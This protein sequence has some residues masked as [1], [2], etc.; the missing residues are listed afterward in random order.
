M[1]HAA[2]DAEGSWV[3][4]KAFRGVFHAS[5]AL[6]TLAG[7]TLASPA[8][9]DVKAG[10]DAWA[11]G[12]FPKAVA[13]WKGPAD[14][15]DPDAQFNLAQAYKLGRG[16][17]R[18]FTRAESLYASA[19]TKGHLQA[20]DNYGL[21]LFQRGERAKAMPYIRAAAE[22]GDARA[23]YIYGLAMFNADGVE[24][25]W[26]R[27]Y[28]YVSMAQQS[29]LPQ[30]T[31]A[32]AQMDQHIAMADRQKAVVLAGKLAAETEARRARQ[33]A[34]M[35]LGGMPGGA[36]VSDGGGGPLPAPNVRASSRSPSVAAVEKA[37]SDAARVAA[38]PAVRAKPAATVAPPRR[39]AA[40]PSRPAS[41]P[42]RVQLG[43][44]GVAGNADALWTRVRNRP[45]LAGHGKVL[46][47]AGKLTKLQA[48]GFASQAEAQ[49]ACTRLK[50][51]GFACVPASS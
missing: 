5:L 51:G 15:G 7:L 12:D 19:A 30:A 18:D 42:W 20:S 35:D 43:A 32:L 27:A 34:A 6:G 45:E 39:A 10:V 48:G 38:Q 21:M 16:V 26:L 37:A 14:A 28:A 13:E 47:P 25:D 9:A 22:R 3:L 36:A 29:G 31:G 11:R 24:K 44:F 49:A 40:A 4:V 41:G 2:P 1:L 46:V 50:S 33:V 17:P 8:L 23:Q